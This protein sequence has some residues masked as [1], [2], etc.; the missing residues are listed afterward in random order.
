MGVKCVLETALQ[1]REAGFAVHWLHPREKRPVGKEWQ[2]R[3]FPTEDFL[4]QT[5]RQNYNIGV[6]L[7]EI[8]RIAGGY[9]HVL[10]LDIRDASQSQDAWEALRELF[11]DVDFDALPTVQ[12][13]SGGE[14]RHIY[15][16]SGKPF[17]SKKMATSEGKFRGA[18]NRWH[19]DWEI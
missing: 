6:R 3:P 1:F 18:D 5:Y 2:E 13:G 17:R 12:S 14:S 8:S 10:D 16:V 9:V 7:G 11:P 19:R 4:R 15:F